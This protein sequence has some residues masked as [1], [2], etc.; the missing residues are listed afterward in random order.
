MEIGSGSV[1]LIGTE[2]NHIYNM[3]KCLILNL[4]HT[5]KCTSDYMFS[6]KQ[7]K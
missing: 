6:R 4:L 7:A 3:G 5:I 2:K 1:K